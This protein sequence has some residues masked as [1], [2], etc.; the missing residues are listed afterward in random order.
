MKF[1]SLSLSE[2][3][4]VAL[5]SIN[6]EDVRPI[7]QLVIP[8]AVAGRNLL[9]GSQT[10]SGK[11]LAY[12]LPIVERLCA[13]PTS[14]ALILAPTRELVQQIST[15]ASPLCEALS[16]SVATIVG[17]VEYAPQREA[18]ATSPDIIVATPGRLIDLMKQGVAAV[19]SL[20]CFVLDEV[21]QM[22]DLGF[23]DSIIHLADLRSPDAQ[24]LFFS[25]TLPDDVCSMASS[26]CPNMEQ[27]TIEGESLSVEHVEQ[28]GYFV[29]FAM[30]D[31]L[32]LHLL[33]VES[34]Q[35]SIIF[36]R[37]RKMA[38]RV[39]GL[40][41]ENSITAEAMHSD[42]S[43]AAREHILARFRTGETSTIVATDV[44]AR[45]I[46][47]DSVS[48][49]FNFG[50]PQNAEQYIHRVGRCGRAGQAGRAISL[51]TPDEKPMLDSICRLMKRHV[52]LDNTHPYMT[53]DVGQALS[54]ALAT[55]RTK[56]KR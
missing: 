32:L 9:V 6:I 5:Q 10:G 26:L 40:L 39:V 19:S 55:K 15:V 18:L 22:L 3:L 4:V 24:S 37:S 44:I 29:S 50:L 35:H 8:A 1:Q 33:R 38:D 7:Q 49:V 51:M 36:T 20:S 2:S 43:Q 53:S 52:V 34:A 16:L 31:H 17:G 47:I 21:D 54:G 12:L 13:A 46:D 11:T 28:V 27:I 30:M 42:R 56:K 14:R 25:A 45:G 48:H 41:A 23:R